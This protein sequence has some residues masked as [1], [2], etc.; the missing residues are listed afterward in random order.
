M[1]ELILP[2][3]LNVLSSQAFNM[4]P[5]ILTRRVIKLEISNFIPIVKALSRLN[6]FLDIIPP[7]L[8]G[9]RVLAMLN[10]GLSPLFIWM[11]LTSL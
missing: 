3:L 10:K 7:H 4:I 6:F 11:T 5:P 9:A 2:I 1:Q 8:I